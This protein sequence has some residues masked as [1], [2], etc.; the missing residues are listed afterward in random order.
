MKPRRALVCLALAFA[1]LALAGCGSAASEQRTDTG[2][3]QTP[4]TKQMPDS[5]Q[6]GHPGPADD[7]APRT[8]QESKQSEKPEQT[9]PAV[10]DQ[11][12]FTAA[13]VSG[14]QFDAR[15]LAGQDVVFWFW[16][17]WCTVCAGSAAAV[18]AA[19]KAHPDVEFVG[20]A[21]SSSDL[22]SM[23]SFVDQHGLTA[24]PQLADTDGSLYTRFGVTQQHTFV[25]VGADGQATTVPAYGG[26]VDLDATIAQQFG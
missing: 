25:L 15:G 13:Q 18:D 14:G 21:G 4:S 11:L 8:S 9:D 26:S 22:N 1:L 12:D 23:Q 7:P 2:T 6:K 16:A 3:G 20:V 19:V 17:P 24:F 10:P 5:K